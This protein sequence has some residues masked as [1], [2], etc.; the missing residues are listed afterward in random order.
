MKV[1]VVGN[2]GREHA[3]IHSITK[4]SLVE[5]VFAIPGN[6]G[7]A[8]IAKCIGSNGT[9]NS[10][11]IELVK[12]Y[13]IDLTIVGPETYIMRGIAND[14]AKENLKIF[15][16]TKEAGLIEGSKEYAK[17]IMEKYNVKTAYYKSFTTFDAA[18]D[19]IKQVNKYPIVIKYD[20][21]AAG[22][23]V[24]I[25]N[26][27]E[28][29]KSVL[30]DLLQNKK[31]GDDKV[32][33]EEFLVGEEFTLM[34]LVHG[35]TVIPLPVARDFKKVF[36]D[37]KG[38]NTGGM[39][40]ICPYD[41]ISKSEKCEAIQILKKTANGLLKEGRAFT[42]ILYGGFISTEDGVKVIEFNARFGD[43]ET[44]VV[45]QRIDSD[46]LKIILDIMDD[47]Y[48][49]V[50]E[51][52]QVY[53]GVVLTA[54]G[55]PDNYVKNVDVTKFIKNNFVNY[56]MSTQ[57]EEGKYISKGGRVVCITNS[58]INKTESFNEIYKFLSNI[59]SKNI[60]FR[61]DLKNY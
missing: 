20:G 28:E 43:P 8:N 37:D 18:N 23:G 47:K 40:C 15:C 11:I 22:K 45:L 4:S 32:I 52:E 5:E 13:K 57:F 39:G 21:L 25:L 35:N 42:G 54:K 30:L 26:N 16:P 50:K 3:I 55:Y 10:E 17:Y 58:G 59:S 19:Y 41:K 14:F 9:S 2:G 33:I 31:L 56:H 6:G 44:E 27:Y 38:K 46:L 34:A 12:K 61:T 7:I 60:H 53:T 51:K 1:L 36:N 49:V 24:Y 29:T 48:M